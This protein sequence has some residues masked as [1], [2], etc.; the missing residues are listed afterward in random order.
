MSVAFSDGKPKYDDFDF[1]Y[2]DLTAMPNPT[3]DDSD[4]TPNALGGASKPFEVSCKPTWKKEKFCRCVR[5]E[6]ENNVFVKINLTNQQD[7]DDKI[8]KNQ[9]NYTEKFVSVYSQMTIEADLQEQVLGLNTHPPGSQIANCPPKKF[10]EDVK[11]NSEAHFAAQTE[12]LNKMLNERITAHKECEDWVKKKQAKG[13]GNDD[14]VKDRIGKC[15][16]LKD[17]IETIKLNIPN[18]EDEIKKSDY[19]CGESA[20][21]LTKIA[22]KT[23]LDIALAYYIEIKNKTK[24][25]ATREMLKNLDIEG[26][27]KAGNS[28]V[29][30][31]SIFL[32]GFDEEYS[33]AG[34]VTNRE[35]QCDGL[36]DG[37]KELCI[38]LENTNTSLADDLK[39]LYKFKPESECISFS[40]FKTFKGMPEPELLNA[41]T[42][43]SR[44]FSTDLLDTPENDSTELKKQRLNFLRAN[45]LIAKVAQNDESRAKLG[46]MLKKLGKSLEGKNDFQKFNEYLKFMKDEKS[47]LKS[48]LITPEAQSTEMY[49]CSQLTQNFTAI[50][51]SNDLPQV[52]PDKDE[53]AFEV[54]LRKIKSCQLDEHNANTVTKLEETLQ[55]SPIFLLAPKDVEESKKNLQDEFKAFKGQYCQG[56]QAK[57]AGYTGTP[58]ERRQK[59]LAQSPF[60]GYKE[61]F[62]EN[63]ITGG[64]TN[65]DWNEARRSTSESRHDKVGQKIWNLNHPRSGNS[66]VMLKGQEDQFLG[67]HAKGRSRETDNGA[68][69]V[70]KSPEKAVNNVPFTNTLAPTPRK[71]EVVNEGHFIPSFLNQP[72]VTEINENFASNKEILKEISDKELKRLIKESEKE[73]ANTVDKEVIKE[74]E[75]KIAAYTEKLNEKK[76][77]PQKSINRIPATEGPAGGMVNNKTDGQISNVENKGKLARIFNK[78]FNK[79]EESLKK[80]LNQ[81]NESNDKIVVDKSSDFI[82]NTTPVDIQGE[83]LIGVSLTPDSALYTDIST[84]PDKLQSYLA[85]N[86]TEIP[87]NKIISIKCSGEKCDKDKSEI[88]LQIVKDGN[89]F[90]VSSVSHRTPV[91]RVHRSS[92]LNHTLGIERKIT[93]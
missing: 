46:S 51:V 21:R 10:A 27:F 4:C 38:A 29:E 49:I 93:Q 53:D 87:A 25:T 63:G 61:A 11:I 64:G 70:S 50:Q 83:V 5:A 56:Y 77:I 68:P 48:L 62:D 71:D 44:F 59:F 57:I 88:F 14:S 75:E 2:D 67:D 69:K 41:F 78:V 60:N 28:P 7:I 91:T 90:V 26:C 20:S 92:D 35:A 31:A 73:I 18:K 79:K 45:P 34:G 6:A 85:Q 84:D 22:L 47:G 24:E 17:S 36:T 13:K 52:E 39:K 1:W 55:A 81:A 37:T 8:E 15:S 58:E 66:P 19:G 42:H 76:E 72:E 54:N 89:K 43:A 32:V 9:I 30:M 23:R 80:A 65:I 86:L 40:E 12:L 3:P 82:F 74:H 33:A 16:K